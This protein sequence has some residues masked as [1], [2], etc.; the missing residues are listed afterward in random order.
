MSAIVF[1]TR[2]REAGVDANAVD[3]GATVVPQIA[4]ADVL[5]QRP[6]NTAHVRVAELAALVQSGH[7]VP[8]YEQK[9]LEVDVLLN[10]RARG[11]FF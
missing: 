9:V 4:A 6:D 1:L 3:L 11:L 8:V 2:V 7:V 5:L 10:V